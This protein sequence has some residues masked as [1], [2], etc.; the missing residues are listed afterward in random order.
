ML[1]ERSRH[2]TSP[3]LFE[4]LI[5]KARPKLDDGGKVLLQGGPGAGKTFVAKRLM[6]TKNVINGREL[7]QSDSLP[8]IETVKKMLEEA[9]RNPEPLLIDDVDLIFTKE[10]YEQISGIVTRRRGAVL[11]TSTLPSALNVLREAR[12]FGN[13]E[14]WPTKVVN[15]LSWLA[16]QLE[17]Y[18][19]NPWMPGWQRQIVKILQSVLGAESEREDA[20]SAWWTIVLHL[21]GGHPTLLDEALIEIRRLLEIESYHD[22][23]GPRREWKQQYAHLEE[24]LQKAGISRLRR[25]LSWWR[26]HYPEPNKFLEEFAA[27]KIKEQDIPALIRGVL[28]ESGWTH[29]GN[30]EGLVVSGAVLR[31]HLA[32]LDNNVPTNPAIDVNRRAQDA[33]EIVVRV[34]DASI[35]IPLNGT[36]WKIV[37]ALHEFGPMSAEDLE[38]KAKVGGGALRSAL[39]RLREDLKERGVEAVIENTRGEGYHLGEFPMLIPIPPEKPK[40]PQ[41]TKKTGARR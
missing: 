5:A 31:Q 3:L 18:T 34:A 26:E 11:M 4:W 36:Q 22:Y 13:E 7:R 14:E 16:Q 32:G 37:S 9:E 20:L 21:T 19:V 10:T 28:I 12:L 30:T 35:A 1:S 2:S 23:G 15:A 6:A 24:Y 39:Q 29:R 33:G 25:N 40:P 8:W 27:S 17:V 41:Q 38:A